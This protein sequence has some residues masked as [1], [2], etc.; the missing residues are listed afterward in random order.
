MTQVEER[1]QRPVSGL[2]RLFDLTGRDTTLSR[3]IRG[4]VTTFLAMAYIIP[5]NPI[6]LG[7]ATDV[8]GARLSIPQ[9]TTMTALSAAI[10]TILMGVVGNV[11]MALAA[12]LGVSA[13]ITFQAAPHMT[14]PQAMGLA[15]LQG[16][17][18][19]ILAVTGLRQWIMNAIPM[20]LKHAMCVGIGCFIALI[21]MVDAGFVTQGTITPLTLGVGG[22]L[23]GWP[24]LVF[25]FGLLLMLILFTRR[26]P[27]AILIGIVAAT[28]LAVIIES[29]V[30]VP[31]ESW[32]AVVP[33]VSRE[34]VSA[35]DFGLLG[36]VDL[37]G[38][39]A[40]AGMVTALV[41]L[42]TLVLSGFFDAMGTVIG[43]ADEAGLV[44]ARGQVPGLGRILAMDGVS[45][46][47]G[48]ATST[49]ANT[50]FVESAAGI[51]EGARTGLANIMTGL[52]FA[53]MI[54]L[55]PLASMVPAQAA[56]PALVVVGGLMMTQV[57]K[58]EWADLS[59]A[60]PAFITIVLMP[61]T[62]SITTGIGAGLISYVA[63]KTGLGRWREIHV[64]LWPVVVLFL[65]FFA[66]SP[67]ERLLGAG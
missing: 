46:A 7:N 11:P 43:L 13:I 52:L 49:S 27:G 1:P 51:A 6:I 58:M 14:W 18:I 44:D 54:F 45:V 15:V 42:F 24:V 53:V 5:L 48:G 20:P 63:I 66:I 35:P 65:C 2:D 3:E 4:G 62:Y 39:F 57:A 23:N 37:F 34:L 10:S 30:T 47:L 19:V 56:A 17:I 61:F 31:A 33:R 9:L 29:T 60:L 16:A 21:G 40:R 50:V 8:T 36:K 64:A 12:G 26:L 59:L 41:L 67:L 28:V 32:G 25:C 55:T 38:G 22:R